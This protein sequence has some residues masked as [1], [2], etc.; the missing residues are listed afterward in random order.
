MKRYR[1]VER[2]TTQHVWDVLAYDKSEAATMIMSKKVEYDHEVKVIS[3]HEH[4]VK[5]I[6]CKQVERVLE[7]VDELL[8]DPIR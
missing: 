1:V 4:E 3:E 8:S 5:V 2:V 7:S 6:S